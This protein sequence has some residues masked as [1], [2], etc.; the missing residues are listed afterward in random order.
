MALEAGTLGFF[1]GQ[2]VRRGEGMMRCENP[3][4]P[5]RLPAVVVKCQYHSTA[6]QAE[7]A[8]NVPSKVVD[9]KI[10]PGLNPPL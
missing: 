8:R 1:Y 5:T 10:V 9:E 7:V 6:S 3:I 4:L 2:M